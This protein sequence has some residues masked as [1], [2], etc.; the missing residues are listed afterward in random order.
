MVQSSPKF[1]DIEIQIFGIHSIVLNF[2][3]CKLW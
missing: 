1:V 3:I 2:Y